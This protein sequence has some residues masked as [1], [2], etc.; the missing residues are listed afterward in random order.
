[1]FVSIRVVQMQ[2]WL[3]ENGKTEYV[4]NEATGHKEAI[5]K[6][7][8]KEEAYDMARSEFYVIRQE[9]QIEKRIAHEEARM[10]GAYFGK[11]RL[12]ISMEL[13][14]DT[15][16]RWKKWA[17]TESAQLQAKRDAAYSS[18]GD[19]EAD[20]PAVANLLAEDQAADSESA[21]PPPPLD[22]KGPQAP[23]NSPRF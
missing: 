13:E 7:L 9:E 21:T 6:P 23:R 4:T 17:E 20:S 15:F 1:M 11:D 10:V 22:G 8:S 2:M 16:E 5:H 19:E 14:D 12:Q 18:F 3:M